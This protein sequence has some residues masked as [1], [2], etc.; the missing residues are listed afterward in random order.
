MSTAIKEKTSFETVSKMREN[1]VA[2]EKVNH[3]LLG[4]DAFEEYSADSKLAKQLEEIRN[5]H[6]AAKGYHPN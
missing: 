1:I 3:M 6:P 2:S 5:A 4:G